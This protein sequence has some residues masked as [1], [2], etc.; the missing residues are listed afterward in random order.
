[1]EKYRILKVGEVAK[2]SQFAQIFSVGI[3]DSPRKRSYWRAMYCDEF[4]V[5]KNEKRIF[6][7]PNK[8]HLKDLEKLMEVYNLHS[9]T[10]RAIQDLIYPRK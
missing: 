2:A 3:N 4:T 7:T 1:M 9:Q 10:Q 6:R 8:E 5:T